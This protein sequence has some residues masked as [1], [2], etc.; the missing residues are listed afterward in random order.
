MSRFTLL[1]MSLFTNNLF[2]LQTLPSYS[3]LLYIRFISNRNYSAI[4]ATLQ[5]TSYAL[6]V[7]IVLLFTCQLHESLIKLYFKQFSIFQLFSWIKIKVLISFACLD[8]FHNGFSWTIFLCGLTY[9][10]FRQTI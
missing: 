1:K 7:Y 2:C 3:V 5:I 4:L 8:V 6:G 10:N 9:L